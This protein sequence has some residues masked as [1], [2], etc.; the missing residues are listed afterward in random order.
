M[1]HFEERLERDLEEIRSRVRAVGQA[2]EAALKKAVH[3]VL[4]GDEEAASEVILGD[5]PINREIRSIDRLCHAFVAQ[6]L[7][8]AGHLRFV[9]AVLRLNVELERVG[10]YAVAIAR[11]TVQM[12]AAPAGSVARDIELISDQARR[13]LHQALQAFDSSNAELARGTKALAKQADKTFQKV[14]ADL[15]LE[16]ERGTWPLRDLFAFLVVINRLGRVSDQAKNICEDTLFAVAG[17]MKEPKTYR[18]LFVDH[19]NA[20][21]SQLAEAYASK[22]F[23]DYGQFSSAGWEPADRIAPAVESFLDNNNL[24]TSGLMTK[25]LGRSV[26]DLSEYD[27]IVGLEGEL[28][29]QIPEVGRDP[30]AHG[31]DARQG[32]RLIRC[33]EI[34]KSPDCPLQPTAET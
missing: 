14:F 21:L 17:E 32:G 22:A 19:R 26:D 24:T 8:S 18:I 15:L 30:R 10:D 7:P 3:T 13:L 6:H 12:S 29:D 16:G 5:L 20:G 1:S 33:L 4:S 23:G 27:V 34:P 28:R 31:D 25:V 11:E 9:S 2:V